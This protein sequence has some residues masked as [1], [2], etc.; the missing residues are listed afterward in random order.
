MLQAGFIITPA[1]NALMLLWTLLL[2]SFW[3]LF[4]F[5]KFK[6]DLTFYR[7]NEGL[8]ESL[9]KKKEHKRKSY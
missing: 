8:L 5:S 3:L 7:W 6:F 2:T 4:S 9:I 1:Y